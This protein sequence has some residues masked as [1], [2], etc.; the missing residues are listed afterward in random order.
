MSSAK[1][2]EAFLDMVA[3]EVGAA[4]ME[5]RQRCLKIVEELLTGSSGVVDA[6]ERIRSG[7]RDNE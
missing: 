4:I 3:R 2:T 7:W 1:Q 5:E 6:V